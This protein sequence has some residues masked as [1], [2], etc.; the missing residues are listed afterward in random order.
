MT[1]PATP[2]MRQYHSIKGRY[3]HAL[4]LF[5]LGDF[6]ELFYEDAIAASREL[7]IT[8]TSRNRERGEPVPMCGVPYHAAEGYIAR[9]LRAG[10][11]IAVCDQMEA[12]GPGKKLVRREVVRVITPGTATSLNVLEPKENN[13]LAAIFRPAGGSPIGFAYA[14]VTTG[15]FRAAAFSGSDAD[16]KLRDE[17][18]RLRPREI[19]IPRQASLFAAA[20]ADG[21]VG[22]PSHA[23]R[24]ELREG[25]ETRI[26]EWVFRFDY[27][28]RMLLELFGVA[29]LD[30]F[31]LA[32][33]PHA[34]SAA[35]AVVHYLRETSAMGAENGNH[36]GA[37]LG[38]LDRVRYYEQADALILDI[39]TVRNLELVAPIFF[40][41]GVR[42]STTTLLSALDETT[43]GMGARRN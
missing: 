37:A 3:P 29:T 12:P 26:D 32:G 39:V 31:G 11:K 18:H 13:Y 33:H 7:Q 9:L 43:T 24:P 38:H 28:E 19:L 15:E 14:D 1:E 8:L 10:Y 30:G 41:E 34:V 25:V 40:E 17:L 21:D 27:A 6:Y 22:G 35:G 5:R 23:S 16:E 36:S 4:V 42:G 2:L 20:G